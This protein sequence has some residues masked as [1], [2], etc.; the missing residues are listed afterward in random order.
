MSSIYRYLPSNGQYESRL[1]EHAVTHT[2]QSEEDPPPL[3]ASLTQIKIDETTTVF[4]FFSTFF[5][6]FRMHLEQGR[7]NNR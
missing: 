6:L 5:P 1:I 3:K 7:V 2:D 4:F